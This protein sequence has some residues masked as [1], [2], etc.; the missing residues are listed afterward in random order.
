V[1]TST[2]SAVI[3]IY[4]ATSPSTI[5]VETL[6]FKLVTTASNQT[7]FVLS[8]PLPFGGF[9]PVLEGEFLN[10]QTDTATVNI[11]IVGYYAT[12]T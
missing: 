7:P 10:A 5:T 2:A 8:L 3:Q 11:N 4:G 1:I 9:I 12:K 6:L